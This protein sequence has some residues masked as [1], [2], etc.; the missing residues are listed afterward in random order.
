MGKKKKAIANIADSIPQE[1]A[2]QNLE[3]IRV[4]FQGDSL[5][6]PIV[7]Q[8]IGNKGI[9][10]WKKISEDQELYLCAYLSTNG[11]AILTE[12]KLPPRRASMESSAYIDGLMDELLIRIATQKTA[13]GIRH[14]SPV[15]LDMR[16]HD[17]RRGVNTFDD[18]RNDFEIEG[19]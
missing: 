3:I 10:H 16:L 17:L 14:N 18:N 5:D 15:M 11:D 13:A 8:R 1:I 4:P 2:S 6:F 7:N 19:A 9:L 12:H